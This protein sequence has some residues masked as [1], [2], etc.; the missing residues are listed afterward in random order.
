MLYP[1]SS[2]LSGF[3]LKA[4]IN[5]SGFSFTN[6]VAYFFLFQLENLLAK[7]SPDQMPVR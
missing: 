1:V 3:A 7:I 5:L 2:D 4:F 6:F